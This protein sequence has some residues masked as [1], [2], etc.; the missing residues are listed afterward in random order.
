[1][2][3]PGQLAYEAASAAPWPLLDWGP[4]SSLEI[5]EQEGWARVEAAVI[6][7]CAELA[8]L[9]IESCREDGETD[10]RGARSRVDDAI[11]ALA[12]PSPAAPVGPSEPG[13]SE[14]RG[15]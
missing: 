9:A 1:M 6:E 3:E 8:R 10:M 2:K 12:N 11:R 15:G 5:E 14:T 4:W 7:Q 13:R